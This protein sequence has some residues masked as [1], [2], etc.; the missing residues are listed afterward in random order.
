MKIREGFLLREVAGNTVIVPVGS[1]S[2][3]FNGIITINEELLEKFLAEY[4]VDVEDA[5]EDIRAFIQTLLD[6]GVMDL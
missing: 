1:D 2:V 6:N 5:K 3:D 4:K